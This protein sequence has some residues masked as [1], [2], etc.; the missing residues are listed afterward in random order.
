MRLS[1]AKY[2]DTT[3]HTRLAIKGVFS[4]RLH[5]L[6]L[7]WYVHVFPLLAFLSALFIFVFTFPIFFLLLY[8]GDESSTAKHSKNDPI[9]RNI[10]S[11]KDY[12]RRN[13]VENVSWSF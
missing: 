1:S 13:C 2:R 11:A 12:N 10:V 4:V 9:I 8:A 6:S 7:F 5:S 3:A